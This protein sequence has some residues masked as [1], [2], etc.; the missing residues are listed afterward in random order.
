[1]GNCVQREIYPLNVNYIDDCESHIDDCESQ[2]ISNKD[3]HLLG[4][5]LGAFTSTL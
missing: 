1:M 5:Y 4:I 3:W 2:N